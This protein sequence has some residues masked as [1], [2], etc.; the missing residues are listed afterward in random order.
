MRLM[1]ARFALILSLLLPVWFMVAA[2]GV[3]FD[4]WSWRLGLGV[5]I[6]QW[7]PRL[8]IGAFIL[9][10]V[11]LVATLARSPR[12]G[13]RAALVALII[14]VLGFGYLAYVRSQATAIPPIH[15]I[16][17]SPGDPPTYSAELLALREAAGANPVAELSAP[18]TG[19]PAYQGPRF[20]TFA[21][22]SLGQVGQDAY[23]DVKTLT[24]IRSAAEAF[25]AAAAE[26]EAQGWTLVSSDPAAGRLEATAETFW[27]GFKDDV[28]IRVRSGEPG[29][30]TAIDMRST[31]RVGLGDMGANAARIEAYLA[32]LGKRL[33][34]G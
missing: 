11:A 8:L 14:P 34:G 13:W 3:K 6:V 16:A 9:A 29:G 22:R 12:S 30:P 4:L 31:S 18:L 23:P 19:L 32:S 1:L 24:T 25:A 33:A 7:G 5:L 28:V 2:L 27:F 26:V 10:V 15:D 17:T 21:D 20:A